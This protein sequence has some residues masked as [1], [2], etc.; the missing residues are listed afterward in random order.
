M[1]DGFDPNVGS[2][3]DL[4]DAG[5]LWLVLTVGGPGSPTHLPSDADPDQPAGGYAP[6]E[7][8]GLVGLVQRVDENVVNAL[9]YEDFGPY[10]RVR[11]GLTA[12]KSPEQV[13]QSVDEL[14]V[15]AP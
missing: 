15:P 13:V 12:A 2:L 3:T 11:F 9:W 14:V 6:F 4:L 8:R 5:G 10:T 1:P 7:V